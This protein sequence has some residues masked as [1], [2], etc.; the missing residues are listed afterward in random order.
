LNIP[1]VA[2]NQPYYTPGNTGSSVVNPN[3]SAPIPANSQTRQPGWRRSSLDGANSNGDANGE[4]RSVLTS[5]TTFVETNPATGQPYARSASAANLPG[6]GFSY[7]SSPNYQTTRTDERLDSTRLPV[8]DASAVRAPAMNYPAA[9]G[10]N[11]AQFQQRPVSYPA[12]YTVPAGYIAPNPAQQTYVAQNGY[13]Q[14]VNPFY[15]GTAVMVARQPRGPVSYQGQTV[16]TNPNGYPVYS[17]P[18]IVAQST[19]TLDS[20]SGQSDWRNRELNSERF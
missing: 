19:A 3:L 2:Q 8:S 18:S 13:R 17:S 5:P 16:L 12:G 7:T 10:N 6:S 9:T 11:L 20:N 14:P 15:N 1:S 4:S